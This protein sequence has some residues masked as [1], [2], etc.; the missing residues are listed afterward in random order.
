MHLLSPLPLLPFSLDPTPVRLPH[1]LCPG[2]SSKAIPVIVIDD[3]H[4]AELIV[5]VSVFIQ[6]DPS[7]ALDTADH[8]LFLETLFP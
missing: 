4:I 8:S 7:V 6:L 1:P 2:L 5:Q 3:I